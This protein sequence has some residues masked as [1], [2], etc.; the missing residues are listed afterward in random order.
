MLRPLKFYTKQYTEIKSLKV[1]EIIK[2]F[3]DMRIKVH[4]VLY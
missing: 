4:L 3:I 1:A 2:C